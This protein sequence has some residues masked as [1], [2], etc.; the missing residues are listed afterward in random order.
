MANEEFTDGI[1]LLKADHRKVEELFDKFE[2]ARAGSKQKIAEQICNE[3]KIHTII[4]EQIFYPALEGKIDEDLLN[5][6]YVEHDA[7]KILVND[8]MA[9]TVRTFYPTA[10]DYMEVN[11][12]ALAPREEISIADLQMAL[13][14]RGASIQPGDAVL[15]R[16]GWARHWNDAELFIGKR[17]GMPGPGEQGTRWLIDRGAT[18]VG[19][20]TPGFECL[21]TPGRSVHAMLLVDE[22]IHIIEN[23]N[24]D[25]L[26]SAG[27][28]SILL[29]ALPLRLVGSTGSPI[30]PIAIA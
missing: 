3:L 14:W 11:A 9:V 15:I 22:G 17:G 19:S 26:A 28:S 30:R 12:W 8:I 21:P 16:T 13:A 27:I 18:L 6:A 10:P 4:E 20:D 29:I 1:A 7:A 24:L 23:L 5:E 2:S 25:E